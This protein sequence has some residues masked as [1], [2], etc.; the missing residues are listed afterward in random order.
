MTGH[1]MV[2]RC[3]MT[4]PKMATK[5]LRPSRSL[6]AAAGDHDVS[7][8]GQ[9]PFQQLFCRSLDLFL[10]FTKYRDPNIYSGVYLL[11]VLIV[12]VRAVALLIEF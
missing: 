9:A 4:A 3:T 10:S 12:I 11:L 6:S 8:R 1:L 7:L 2:S 5:R